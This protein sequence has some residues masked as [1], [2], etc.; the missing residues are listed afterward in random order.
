MECSGTFRLC[1]PFRTWLSKF[2][3][4]TIADAVLDRSYTIEIRAVNQ[5]RQA[6]M[7]EV[8]GLQK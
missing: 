7:R 5:E 1:F 4:A 2:P 8:Y 3:E 6:S